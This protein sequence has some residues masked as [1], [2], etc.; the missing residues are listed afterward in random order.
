[1][2]S[3]K[4]STKKAAKKT[5]VDRLVEEKHP[6]RFINDSRGPTAP[7]LHHFV[8]VVSGEHEGRYG[9]FTWVSDDEKYGV[10]RTRDARTDLLNVE[11]KDLRPALAGRR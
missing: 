7:I 4:A 5:E 3:K 2:T 9:V 6:G 11:V 10:V 8:D 1:M